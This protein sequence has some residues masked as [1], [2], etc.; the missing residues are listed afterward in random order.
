M[1]QRFPKISFKV[2]LCNSN[3]VP[4]SWSFFYDKGPFKINMFGNKEIVILNKAISITAVVF[5]GNSS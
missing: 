5:L 1:K 4:N 3:I 2:K